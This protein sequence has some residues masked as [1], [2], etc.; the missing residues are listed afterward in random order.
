[1]TGALVERYV[2]Y[3]TEQNNRLHVFNVSGYEKGSCV[4]EEVDYA[5]IQNLESGVE[6]VFEAVVKTSILPK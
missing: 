2:L 1:M 6:E 5:T 4:S 3:M